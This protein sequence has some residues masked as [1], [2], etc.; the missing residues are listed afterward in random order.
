MLKMEL[1]T[2]NDRR[3]TPRITADVKCWLERESITLLGTVANLSFGGLFLRTPVTL[4]KGHRVSLKINVGQGIIEA[5]GYVVW[6]VSCQKNKGYSGV[7]IRIDEI[8]H[9]KKLF[10]SFVGQKPV[11][12]PGNKPETN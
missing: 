1:Q 11:D 5:L 6:N 12:E 3:L 7:G 2:Q 9:G 8:V 10:A 4:P